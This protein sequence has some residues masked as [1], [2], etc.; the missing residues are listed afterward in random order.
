MGSNVLCNRLSNYHPNI[1]FT[2]EENP[3]K[4]LDTKLT[5][6]NDFYKFNI[7]RKST[8]LPSPSTPTTLKRYK[9]NT[10]NDNLNRPKKNS[11]NFDE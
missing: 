3:C 4:F 9:R 6:I 7:Y 11:S 1:K 8:K 2:I 5:K 10:I